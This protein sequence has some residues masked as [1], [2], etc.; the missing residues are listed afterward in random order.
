VPHGPDGGGAGEDDVG[1]GVVEVG[2]GLG[3]QLW[4]L[5]YPPP[6]AG[7]AVDLGDCEPIA[8]TAQKR[9]KTPASSPDR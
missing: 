6:T 5:Q 8:T 7:A 3:E 2:V 4:W 1:A 9:H